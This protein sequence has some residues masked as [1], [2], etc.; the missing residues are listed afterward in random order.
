MSEGTAKDRAGNGPGSPIRGSSTL[1]SFVA[2]PLP[3]PVR[4]A[5][6]AAVHDG[7]S[8][9]L[10]DAASGLAAQLPD[11]RWSRRAEN[12]H[13]TLKFLGQVDP[14]KLARFAQEL[15]A[16]LRAI[17]GFDI[18][19]R[20]FGAF[21]SPRDA[22]VIWVGVDDPAHRLGQVA[23]ITEEVAARTAVAAGDPLLGK[24]P[25]RAHV[26]VGRLPRRTRRSVDA[27]AA[28][29]PVAE[30]AFG[31]VTVSEVHVYESITGGEASTYVL[32]GTATLEG[33]TH[34]DGKDRDQGRN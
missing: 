8:D 30:Q 31:R 18:R 13:V 2:V 28:L 9:R 14:G 5:I 24:R 3:A 29:A 21:P 27:A 33:A 32:R 7:K 22:Q 25:F 4:A 12:L 10:P 34:G 1:R 15:A 20:G 6:L 16:A 23:A 26:T 19:L 11:I 17:P